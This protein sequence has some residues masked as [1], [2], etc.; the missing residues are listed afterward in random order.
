MKL[1]KTQQKILSRVN[2]CGHMAIHPYKNLRQVK[3]AHQLIAL[4]LVTGSHIDFPSRGDG[5]S[6]CLAL[7]KIVSSN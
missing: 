3:A 5:A 1:T 2:D 6:W 4:G 7:R